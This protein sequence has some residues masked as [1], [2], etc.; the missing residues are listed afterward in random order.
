MPKL[1][2]SWDDSSQILGS[3]AYNSSHGLRRR[4]QGVMEGIPSACFAKYNK[5]ENSVSVFVSPAS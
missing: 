4:S 3:P 2:I 5:T 1:K